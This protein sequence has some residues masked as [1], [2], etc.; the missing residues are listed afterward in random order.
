MKVELTK[1]RET[2]VIKK[3]EAKSG[4]SRVSRVLLEPVE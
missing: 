4:A 3:R 2:K 1:V